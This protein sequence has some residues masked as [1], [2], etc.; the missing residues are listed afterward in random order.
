MTRG[1][2][3]L[4][5]TAAP[6]AR[7]ADA[8]EGA[9]RAAPAAGDA[10]PGGPGRVRV[11]RAYEARSPG[12][13]LRVLVDRLWPR[14]VS[15]AAGRVDEWARDV[16]PSDEL[17]RWYGHRPERFAEF[18]R[19]YDAELSGPPQAEALERLRET[20]RRGTLTLVTATRDVDRSH[21][22]VLARRLRGDDDR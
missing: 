20:A 19:R 4:P 12:E 6:A 13:G 11:A 21:A 22:A 10:G 18:W 9:P 2:G 7:C 17:R 15:R 8:Q 5:E 14:G 1:S 16:A 3:D